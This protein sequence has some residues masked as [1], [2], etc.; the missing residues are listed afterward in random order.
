M[1][2]SIGD[3]QS[4]T[5]DVE[6][7]NYSATTYSEK[8]SAF[9]IVMIV[10][11]LLLV[12]GLLIV[13][14]VIGLKKTDVK[15]N[16][17]NLSFEYVR[18]EKVNAATGSYNIAYS[19]PNATKVTI[20]P[21]KHLSAPNQADNLTNE[22]I[23]P[24][25]GVQGPITYTL[26]AF[27]ASGNSKIATVR[28]NAVTPPSPPVN[29][30]FEAIST[31]PLVGKDQYAIVWTARSPATR[32]SVTPANLVSGLQFGYTSPLNL[33]PSSSVNATATT[34]TTFVLTAYD[35]NNTVLGT[36]TVRLSPY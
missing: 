12:S 24:L 9:N 36:E 2:Y 18:V 25:F 3:I 16:P 33:P 35:T 1:S 32:V 19:S 21:T 6:S 28:V 17:N 7:F 5:I 4:K 34:P 27:N 20:S 31:A 23:V 10:V 30:A 8:L 13:A 11:L 14:L 29:T 26:T 22:G 15:P